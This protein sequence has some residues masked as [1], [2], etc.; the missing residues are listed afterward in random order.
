MLDTIN[1]V[2]SNQTVGLSE[3]GAEL[4]K[5]EITYE[6]V[7]ERIA[8]DKDL[9]AVLNSPAYTDEQKK[10]ITN[11]ITQQVMIELGYKPVETVLIATTEPG[12]DGY[13]VKGYYSLET[14]KAYVNDFYNNNNADLL[15]TAGAETQR[16][17]DAQKG[18]N[19]DQS[20]EYRDA[21]SAYS[22]N[23][24]SN[25]ASYADFALY[26]TGQGSLST[27]SNSISTSPQTQNNNAEFAGLNK[28]LGDNL[29]WSQL[30]KDRA[31]FSSPFGMRKLPG[32]PAR[33]HYGTDITY[34][35][36][37][38]NKIT[39]AIIFAAGDGE[40]VMSEN[41]GASGNLIRIYHPDTGYTSEYLHASELLVKKGTIVKEGQ[42]IMVEGGSGDKGLETYDKHL[43]FGIY[44]G[45]IYDKTK[46]V[47]PAPTNGDKPVNVGKYEKLEDTPYQQGL[48]K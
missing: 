44:T 18:S 30:S 9:A 4:R 24:G 22:Q 5:R 16:A 48:L 47:D 25:I 34:K 13:Q 39:N 1:Q 8:Q 41:R 32:Q 10:A 33:L 38:E 23:F 7:K 26:F 36:A 27:G 45:A 11:G 6:T 17:I 29:I 43:H 12:R 31:V 15:K 40:V 21:R 42:P 28:E 20:K 35:D 14:G 2:V 3:F 37:N 19:F 46:F